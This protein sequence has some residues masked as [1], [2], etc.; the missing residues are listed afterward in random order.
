MRFAANFG[1]QAESVRVPRVDLSLSTP[2]VLT[3]EFV[4]SV[5]LTDISALDRL[6]LDKEVLARNVAETFLQQLLRD[7]YFHC[8]PHPGNLCV[9]E[10]ARAAPRRAA[11]ACPALP[12]FAGGPIARSPAAPPCVAPRCDAAAGD[13]FF[14]APRLGPRARHA[15]R[16]NRADAC[17]RA[18]PLCRR[19]SWCTTTLG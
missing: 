8:D 16:A 14:A 7:G 15:P 1:A 12:P 3:M 6:G 17:R 9:D 18:A 2:R 5:K 10:Q 13:G 4:P 19:A 11:S